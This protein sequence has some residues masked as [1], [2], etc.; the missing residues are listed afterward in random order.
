[1]CRII[2]LSLT[3][4]L[5]STSL[6]AKE[7]EP[8]GTWPFEYQ[9]FQVATVYSGI[10]SIKK[11]QVPCNIHLGKQTLWFSQNDT[12]MEAV[13]GS[14]IR[15]EF[16]NGDVFIPVNGGECMGKIERE[17]TLSG[18][19]GRVL[20]VRLVDQNA[21]D[22][23]AIDLMNKSQNLQQSSLNLGTWGAQLSDINASIN[24]EELPIP[25]INVFYF[26][27]K[28]EIFEAKEKQILSHINPARKREYKNYTRKAEIIST[29][30]SSMLKVWEDFFVNY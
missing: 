27:Y 19:V 22:Q 7:W 24:E 12:L 21:V 23:R 25:L 29:N 1:M 17:D 13:K 11:T 5:C 28:G 18:K 15:V 2:V 16:K 14:I 4:L 30:K 8:I 9:T 3:F 6:F 20:H 10:Y 26:Q